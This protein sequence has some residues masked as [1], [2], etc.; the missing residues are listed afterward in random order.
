MPYMTSGE[1]DDILDNSSSID[2]SDPSEEINLVYHDAKSLTLIESNGSIPI[3]QHQK[4]LD[5][6]KLTLL[7]PKTR[8]ALI[9]DLSLEIHEKDHL[10]VS[11]VC[12]LSKL[13]NLS[14]NILFT[15][16]LLY[17]QVTGP[18]GSGKTS[19]LR[20]L[21]GLWNTGRGKITFYVKSAEDPLLG[22]ASPEATPSQDTYPG[23]GRP[24]NKN[25]SGIFFLPQRPY[26]VLGSL[27]QQL[28]YPTWA[29]DVIPMKDD[30]KQNGMWF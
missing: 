30:D 14:I 10:L 16:M 21:A 4:L 1:F 9:Q 23:A 29:E 24:K 22:A 13:V 18:S 15:C 12:F 20:A 7:T 26:M 28:L 25:S 3:Y 2:P 8:T 6:E 5:I 19:L 17:P 27:R 11:N